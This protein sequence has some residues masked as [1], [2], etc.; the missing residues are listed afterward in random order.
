[1]AIYV[2]LVNYSIA[3]WKGLRLEARKPNKLIRNLKKN[4]SRI[5]KH[6]KSCSNFKKFDYDSPNSRELNV[7]LQFGKGHI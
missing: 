5:S 3:E 7:E 6:F 2:F 4:G 1:M